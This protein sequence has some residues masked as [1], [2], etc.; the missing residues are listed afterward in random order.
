M[1]DSL[2]TLRHL[3]HFTFRITASIAALFFLGWIAIVGILAVL[4]NPYLILAY[5]FLGFAGLFS[6]FG[7]IVSAAPTPSQP[8]KVSHPLRAGS[9][10][11][12]AGTIGWVFWTQA[13]S[14]MAT[15]AQSAEVLGLLL[16]TAMLLGFLA[17]CV[18]AIL[19]VLDRRTDGG[20][21]EAQAAAAP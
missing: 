9:C 15:R 10:L 6:C 19:L 3:S 17:M 11:L 18:L 21:P 12:G 7:A 16:V 5:W 8:G 20:S 14:A 4:A 2:S 13:G 1:P